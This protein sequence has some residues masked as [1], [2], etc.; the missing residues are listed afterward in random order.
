MKRIHIILYTLLVFF[1]CN[2][3]N[4][5]EEERQAENQK[6]AQDLL[7]KAR[8][9]LAIWKKYN[10]YDS[11]IWENT[12]SIIAV[13]IAYSELVNKY[14]G[15]AASFD[16]ERELSEA[17]NLY[18]RV[19]SY[20]S[21]ARK[22][23]I[24]K[25][26]NFFSSEFDELVNYHENARSHTYKQIDSFEIGQY[27]SNYFTLKYNTKRNESYGYLFYVKGGSSAVHL[28][29]PNKDEVKLTFHKSH[30]GVDTKFY[31][32]GE[33][34]PMNGEHYTLIKFPTPDEKKIFVRG[35]D[36]FIDVSGRG[37]KGY[38]F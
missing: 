29:S 26:E 13:E 32:E 15:T 25:A 36:N 24:E 23:A 35:W 17:N 30:R 5:E 27:R 7:K 8:H 2:C 18:R 12:S 33:R 6:E 28:S 20:K 3:G 4:K 19:S 22:R 31:K 10:E 21:G 16:A 34:N 11:N 14:R 1:L 38:E 9:E 37:H